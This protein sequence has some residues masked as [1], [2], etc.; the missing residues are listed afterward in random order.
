MKTILGFDLGDA[1]FL[2]NIWKTNLSDRFL[3]S[4]L[5]VVWAI[6]NP[7]I[8]FALFTFV[9]AFVFKAR[10]PGADSSITYSIWLI[11]GYGPWLANIEALMA[12]SNSIVSNAG[13]VKNMTF[14]T[15]ILPISATM[16]GIV[17]LGVSLV[18]LVILKFFT[19]ESFSWALALLPFVIF[20]QFLFL[21]ALGVLFAIITTFVRDFGILLPNLL[22]I[23]LFATP[24]FYPI[25]TLP[26]IAQHIQQ[27]NPFYVISEAYRSV[28]L[29]QQSPNFL[30]IVILFAI[31]WLLIMVNLKMFRRIKGFFAAII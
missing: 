30:A 28:L 1:R 6:L 3:G 5:G 29:G 20:V 15:E 13:L 31:S 23:C 27:F 24:I 8:M 12:S 16:I 14:K 19:G 22:L 2:Y 4:A 26:S 11:C 21:S 7:L 10:I 25:E 17:P 9:F 18:F